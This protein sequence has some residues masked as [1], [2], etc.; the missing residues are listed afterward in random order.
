MEAHKYICVYMCVCMSV[1][2][3]CV[4]YMCVYVCVCVC[5]CAFKQKISSLEPGAK[6]A[7]GGLWL[8]KGWHI[9][10]GEVGGYHKHSWYFGL[11]P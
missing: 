3:M 11:R 1:I 2:Y 4:L 8:F 7:V 10:K 6:I 5:V 9:Q